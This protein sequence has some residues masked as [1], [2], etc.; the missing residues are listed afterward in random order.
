LVSSCT[1]GSKTA[2]GEPQ[3]DEYAKLLRNMSK[4]L[5]NPEDYTETEGTSQ[6]SAQSLAQPLEM[7]IPTQLSGMRLD[8]A[9]AE[10]LPRY[11][12]SRLQTWITEGAGHA[13]RPNHDAQMQSV[14]WRAGAGAAGGASIGNL[15]PGGSDRSRYRV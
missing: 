10:L 6:S 7:A 8:Q 13:G 12:R 2:A 11:S 4:P 9:L 3:H 1:S 15:C 14:G 5:M